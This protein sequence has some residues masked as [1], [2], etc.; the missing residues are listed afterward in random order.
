MLNDAARVGIMGSSAGGLVAS[1][2]LPHFE[3]GLPDSEYPGERESARLDL[4]I[5]RHPGI[6]PGPA[7]AAFG[8]TERGQSARRV[9]VDN[10]AQPGGFLG[11]GDHLAGGRAGP[12]G[13]VL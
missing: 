8:N 5:L 9:E 10:S 7:S 6:A 1:T 3:A 2:L 12:V 11:A 4:G 13:A